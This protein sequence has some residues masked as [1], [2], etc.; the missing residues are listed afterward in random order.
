GIGGKV[1]IKAEESIALIGLVVDDLTPEYVCPELNAVSSVQLGEI[2]IRIEGIFE[3]NSR[4]GGRSADSRV[5]R[6]RKDRQS[7]RERPM[8][9]VMNSKLLAQVG[10]RRRA[11]LQS[12]QV[13]SSIAEA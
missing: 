7:I 1:L 10:A 2:D 13:E 5:V 12:V 8:V 9:G 4:H 11:V 3:A 6:R